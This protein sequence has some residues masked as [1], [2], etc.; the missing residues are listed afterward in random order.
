M[1][2]RF[3]NYFIY[4]V[5]FTMV[6]ALVLPEGELVKAALM[7]GGVFLPTFLAGENL[8][9]VR[10]KSR[11]DRKKVVLGIFTVGE[12]LVTVSTLILYIAAYRIIVVD[13]LHL[14]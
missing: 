8:M 4:F 11:L 12:A 3:F 13:I 10:T 1:A 9:F 5:A 14:I 7:S 6:L 2:Q